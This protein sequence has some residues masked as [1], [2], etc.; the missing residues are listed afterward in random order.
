MGNSKFG[1]FLP[2][3]SIRLFLAQ[4]LLILRL[5][6][7]ICLGQVLLLAPFRRA[8][9]FGAQCSGVVGGGADTGLSKVVF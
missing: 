8:S 5:D 4:L 9:H 3:R 7:F 2:K 1:A 6:G